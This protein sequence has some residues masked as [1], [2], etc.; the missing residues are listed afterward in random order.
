MRE[1]TFPLRGYSLPLTPNGRSSLVE[2]PPWHY[3]ADVLLIFYKADETHVKKHLPPP[4][5]LGTD[6]GLAFVWFTE[7]ISVSDSNLHLAF[8]N[9]ERAQY[10]ECLLGLKCEINGADGFFIPYIW[11]DNDFTLMRGFIQGFPKKLGRIYITRL[12]ELLPKIGGKKLGA[13]IKGICESQG[14]KIVSGSLK[15]RRK[16]TPDAIPKLKFFLMRHFPDIENPDKP[17]VHEISESIIENVK[18]GDVWLGDSELMFGRSDLGGFS[19]L[20]PKKILK[21]F[22]FSIGF[23]ISGGRILHR[24][25]KSFICDSEKR[26]SG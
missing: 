17:S 7:I 3:G 2:P 9:P 8:N 26:L 24:Y 19:S 25:K 21:G 22:Y 6:P 16:T 10:K 18:F 11:V 13:K 1:K 4:L 5:K 12:H 23:T 20:S 14:E 15:F